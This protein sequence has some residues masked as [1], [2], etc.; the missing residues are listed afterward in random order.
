MN[1]ERVAQYPR[2]ART[3]EEAHRAK[4]EFVCGKLALGPG[5]RVL[6]RLRLRLGQLRDPLWCHSRH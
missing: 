2:G 4:R 5:A 3:L 6:R 1:I